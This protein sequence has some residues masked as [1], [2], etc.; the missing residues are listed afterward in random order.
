MPR[1]SIRRSPAP[2]RPRPALT[3]RGGGVYSEGFRAL[4]RRTASSLFEVT[5]ILSVLLTLKAESGGL[6][7]LLG[8]PGRLALAHERG[9]LRPLDLF[10]ALL[11]P[12]R[13][14]PP[15]GRCGRSRGGAGHACRGCVSQDVPR[16]V[17]AAARAAGS[18]G[19]LAGARRLLLQMWQMQWRPCGVSIRVMSAGSRLRLAGAIPPHPR[20]RSDRPE[21]RV[22]PAVPH[23]R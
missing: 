20:S 21:P 9:A 2:P 23:L 1:D 12:P 11:L 14:P 19:L 10:L 15:P 5:L 22:G 6:L 17:C 3:R 13:R 7:V 4:G 8:L 18:S 16:E